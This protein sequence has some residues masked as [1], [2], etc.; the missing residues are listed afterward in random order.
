MRLG[1]TWTNFCERLR[2]YVASGAFSLAAFVLWLTRRM[3]R[4]RLL[5]FSDLRYALRVGKALRRL[6][7][8]LIMLKRH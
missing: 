2:L 5:I 4:A 3:Y 8:R 1:D 6:G 7:L